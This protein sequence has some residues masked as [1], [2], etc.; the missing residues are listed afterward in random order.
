[1]YTYVIC[2]V[3]IVYPGFT[4][5]ET[6]GDCGENGNFMTR[7]SPDLNLAYCICSMR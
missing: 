1:M 3:K 7:F 5:K 6:V 2:L 4:Y